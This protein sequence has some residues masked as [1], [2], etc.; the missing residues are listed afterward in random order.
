MTTH[1][2]LPVEIVKST[3]TNR[4][5]LVLSRYKDGSA[6][7]KIDITDALERVLQRE[8]EKGLCE[9]MEMQP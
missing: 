1:K 2:A 9:G 6:K 4:W 5:Y 8:R 3:M 7:K